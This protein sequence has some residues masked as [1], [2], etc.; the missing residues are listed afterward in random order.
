MN[1][2]FDIKANEQILSETIKFI[3]SKENISINDLS[4]S[5]IEINSNI[6]DLIENN[7]IVSINNNILNHFKELINIFYDTLCIEQNANTIVKKSKIMNMLHGAEREITYYIFSLDPQKELKLNIFWAFILIWE[8]ISKFWLLNDNESGFIEDETFVCIDGEFIS[9]KVNELVQ[10]N[11]ER[12]IDNRSVIIITK[13]PGMNEKPKKQF[14]KSVLS[15]KKTTK[16][17]HGAEGLDI[18]FFL[19][20]ILENDK[21]RIDF[22]RSTIDVKYLCEYFHYNYELDKSIQNPITS[23]RIYDENPEKSSIY[24]FGLITEEQQ[25]ELTNMLE[26]MPVL[27]NWDIRESKMNPELLKYTWKDVIYLKY[28]YYRIIMTAAFNKFPLQLEIT[29]ESNQ[30][31]EN[32]NEEEAKE[33]KQVMVTLYT[34]ILS[35]FM[36]LCFLERK[37]ITNLVDQC[38][39][40]VN[41]INNYL[42]NVNYNTKNQYGDLMNI[43]LDD[44]NKKAKGKSK[45]INEKQT[46]NIPTKITLV[47]LYDN[48]LESKITVHYP[49][50][51]LDHILNVPYFK[52][53]V[54]IIIKT[55]LYCVIS[56][57]SIIKQNNVKVWNGKVSDDLIFL[58]FKEYN[59]VYLSMVFLK[60]KDYFI[61][62]LKFIIKDRIRNPKI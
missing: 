26:N 51:N 60:V 24:I 40:I 59:F 49:Y 36:S 8:I 22:L 14:I 13:I 46:N 29:N 43:L 16:I 44:S 11:F 62:I 45:I 61:D 10:L 25:K 3:K 2:N 48:F 18:P 52:S 33:Y 21:D 32:V 23:C 54:E 20:D 28:Y 27:H 38:K 42:I 12:S 9:G 58:Y 35:E 15:N 56:N 55:I 1:S 47:R 6:N 7:V 53:T 5:I 50:C 57:M 17:F 37:L 4:K 34:D 19:K 31:S 41:P 39:E 30:L